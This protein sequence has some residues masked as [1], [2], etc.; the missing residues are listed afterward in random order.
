[1]PALVPGQLQDS[2]LEGLVL[3]H[4]LYDVVVVLVVEQHLA[5]AVGVG[6][7]QLQQVDLPVPNMQQD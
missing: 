6:G 7:L 4:A 2:A 3:L 1:M 5:N